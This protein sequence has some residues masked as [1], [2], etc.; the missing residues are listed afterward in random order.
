ME[1]II[2]KYISTVSIFLFENSNFYHVIDDNILYDS[3]A[4]L[5]ISLKTVNYTSTVHFN[6]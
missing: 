6:M 5:K 3:N 1:T 4:V 2:A